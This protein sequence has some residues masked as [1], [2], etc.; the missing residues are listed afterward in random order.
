[1]AAAMHIVELFRTHST[2]HISHWLPLPPVGAGFVCTFLHYL[3][4]WFIADCFDHFQ[5]GGDP[6]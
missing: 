3:V 4:L 1:M 6:P 5:S 2:R